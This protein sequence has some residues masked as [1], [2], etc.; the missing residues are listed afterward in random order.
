LSNP[1][2]NIK[3]ENAV[4]QFISQYFA[5]PYEFVMAV[6]PWGKPQL[7]DGTP[8]PLAN[9]AGP[10]PWQKE[11]LQELGRH[12]ENNLILEDLGCE[13]RVWRSSIAS[14][15]GV[16]KS[17]LVAWVIYFLMST[18]PDTRGVV[19]ASTQYQLEDKTWPELA[20]WHK[21]ALNKHWFT[22]LAT[23][24]V[25][26]AYPEDQQKNYK[27]TAA[28]VSEQKTEAFAGLHNLGK[29]VFII[30]DEASGVHGKVWEVSEGALL[31]QGEKFF[32]AF[33]NPT[34]P[35]GEF[36]DCFDKHSAL[37]RTRHVDSREVSHSSKNAIQ[38]LIDKYGEDSDEIKVRVKGQFP[39]SSYNGFISV[40]IARMA[41]ERELFP[42]ANSA[43]IMAVDVAHFGLDCSV[44]GFRQGRDARSIPWKRFKG[45]SVPKLAEMAMREAQIHRPDAIVIEGT[46][47]GAGVID[48]MRDRGFKVTTIWPG[49]Q[50][51][52]VGTYANKRAE[53]WARMRD[54]LFEEGCIA[55]DHNLFTQLTS[56][57]YSLQRDN[58]R[59]II[60]S[61]K[62]MK[63]RGLDS[64]D[65]A[66]TLA[67]THAVRLARRDRTNTLV[68][69][70]SKA[71]TDYDEFSY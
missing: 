33:G 35:D 68:R 37:Y 45:L 14:G 3:T 48:I 28:T 34:R 62:D 13:A 56:I 31:G 58:L 18:R 11:F 36:A 41:L 17:A 71:I 23:G 46:G 67:L 53:F 59:L 27:V 21:L 4:S 12:I 29:C 5:K 10:E 2:I 63:S 19:T 54:W 9:F 66:D 57:Q 26:S 61:K 51:D 25:F 52:D 44:I 39:Q 20:K 30:F 43:L 47:I 50:P 49:G 22:W 55:D 32:F 40:D 6:F 16:G 38:T 7:A 8:N 1:N 60:E 69:A 70:N 15:H 42:D 65:T 64:P 24:F